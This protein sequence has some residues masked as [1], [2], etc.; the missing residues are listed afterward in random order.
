MLLVHGF[1]VL[2]KSRRSL[3]VESRLF[4]INRS[5]DL[6]SLSLSPLADDEA[7]AYHHGDASSTSPSASLRPKRPSRGYSRLADDASRH[8]PRW[9]RKRNWPQSTPLTRRNAT[10]CEA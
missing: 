8:F 1:L 9:H 3:S 2:R 7:Y 10:S 6:L 4:W 5:T